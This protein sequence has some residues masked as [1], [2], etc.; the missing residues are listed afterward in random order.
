M[1]VALLFVAIAMFL[2][3]TVLWYWGEETLHLESNG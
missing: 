3:G 1:E 2:S